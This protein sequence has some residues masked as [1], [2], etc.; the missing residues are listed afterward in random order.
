MARIE[1]HA[2]T[3]RREAAI[4]R[5]TGGWCCAAPPLCRESFAAARSSP[6]LKPFRC[7]NSRFGTL[8]KAS[9]YFGV[10][11]RAAKK[12]GSRSS[13]FPPC[14]PEASASPRCCACQPLCRH[15]QRP[16][17]PSSFLRFLS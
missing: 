10:R 6:G 13:K 2:G 14:Q 17:P 3:K 1:A 8:L 11:N 4:M 5:K 16:L 12:R 15:R 9:P 7:R